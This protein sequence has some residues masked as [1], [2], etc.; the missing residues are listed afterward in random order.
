MNIL[1]IIQNAEGGKNRVARA[2]WREFSKRESRLFVA[3]T[4][5]KK[6][7]L[8]AVSGKKREGKSP[9][10]TSELSVLLGI[11]HVAVFKRIRNGRIKAVLIGHSYSIYPDEVR[12]LLKENSI[13]KKL[14]STHK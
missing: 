7:I 10:S 1:E 12:R 5:N 14:L 3:S 2:F 4:K 13:I 8:P 6:R 11:S 9:L